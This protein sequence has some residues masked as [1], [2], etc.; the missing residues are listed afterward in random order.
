MKFSTISNTFLLFQDSEGQTHT[1]SLESILTAGNPID[2]ET[3]DDWELVSGNL[4]NE[5]GEN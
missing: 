1:V 3:G 4:V 5:A 2:P